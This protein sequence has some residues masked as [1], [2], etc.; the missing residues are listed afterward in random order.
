MYTLIRSCSEELDSREM[1]RDSIE[2][3][4]GKFCVRISSVLVQIHHCGAACQAGLAVEGE[5]IHISS[6]EAL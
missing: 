2:E 6:S 1:T 5:L 4:W 3:L